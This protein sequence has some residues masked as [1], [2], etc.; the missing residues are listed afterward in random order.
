[1]AGSHRKTRTEK[2]RIYLNDRF[3]DE[4]ARPVSGKPWMGDA[5]R[6]TVR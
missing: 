3:E 2:L 6:G 4:S 1:M 5:G